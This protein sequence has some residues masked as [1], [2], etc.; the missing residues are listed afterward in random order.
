V[1]T[2][3]TIAAYNY[4]KIK[5]MREEAQMEAHLAVEQ[6]YTPVLSAEPEGR[7]RAGRSSTGDLI[8]SSLSISTT[9]GLSRPVVD[10]PVRASPV[11]RPEDLE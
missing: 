9:G 8:R 4:M 6:E 10:S 7:E 1:V 11:K 5:K 3:A 2:I